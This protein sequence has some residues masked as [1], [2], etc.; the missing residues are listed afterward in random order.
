VV[1]VD[2]N[3]RTA[4]IHRVFRLSNEFGFTN[5]LQS[6]K[7]DTL[8][9]ALRQTS[10]PNLRVVTCGPTPDN[11]WE[12]LRSENLHAVSALLLEVADYVLYDTPSAMMFTDA[13]NLACIVDGA[14]LCVRAQETLTGAEERLVE[15]MEKAGVKVL[16]SVLSD[17][18]AALFD[19]YA[20]YEE[21]YMPA[22]EA[23]EHVTESV[24]PGRP[25]DATRLLSINELP[26]ILNVPGA[27]GDAGYGRIV[28]EMPD[29][30][31]WRD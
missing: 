7:R 13:L 20:N 6:P 25:S 26:L 24:R 2:A 1:I 3:T 9:R 16:G 23:N 18:P 30:R 14:F 5:L 28:A 29:D 22:M 4:E 27:G 17:V 10:T 31:P 11:L 12:L 15:L 21:Y 8:M 19:G